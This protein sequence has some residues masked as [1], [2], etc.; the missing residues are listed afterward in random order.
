MVT[1]PSG[2]ASSMVSSPAGVASSGITTNNI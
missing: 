2:A 1:S